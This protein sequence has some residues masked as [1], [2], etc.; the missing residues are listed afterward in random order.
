MSM[1]S[2]PRR[3]LRRDFRR[4]A[5]RAWIT[6]LAAA[7]SSCREAWRV[8]SAP[9]VG[10]PEAMAVRALRTRVL[11]RDVQAALLARRL[12]ERMMSFLDDLMFANRLHLRVDERIIAHS[13]QGPQVCE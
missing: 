2:V 8:N 11:Q 9:T 10:S 7:L 12:R 3:R 1:P 4:A 6:P 13:R 5:C